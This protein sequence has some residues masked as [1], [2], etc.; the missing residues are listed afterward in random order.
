[1]G[2]KLKRKKR[3]IVTDLKAIYMRGMELYLEEE[4]YV[5]GLKYL[6]RAA[7]AGYKKAYGE[8]GIILYREK[9][10]TDRAEKWF[11]KAEKADSLFPVAAYEY[12]MLFY[13]EKGDIKTSLKYLLQSAKRGCELAYGQIGIILYL[14]K[15]KINEALEWFKK[16]EAA[17]CLFAP[18]AYYFGL[19]LYLEK[20]EGNQSLEYFQKAAREGYDLAYGELGS[21]LYL[22]KAEIDEAEK[23]FQKAEEAGCLHAPH[24][25]DYGMLLIEERGDIERGNRYLDKAAE[26]GY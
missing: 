15:N 12:G 24:A 7:K 11:R 22:E 3:S 20:G 18:A 10:E 13:L 17:N 6:F 1:M 21:V 9:N 25:Y 4:D 26:D 23:W 5:A 19:L 16:A 8:I 2:K 14:E